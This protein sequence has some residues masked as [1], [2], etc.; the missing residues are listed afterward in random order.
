[1]INKNTNLVEWALAHLKQPA[2]HLKQFDGLSN[3]TIIMPTFKRHDY[4]IRLIVYLSAFKVNLIIVVGQPHCLN[5]SSSP[6]NSLKQ[7]S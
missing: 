7:S 3:L 6:I 1:L 4:V 2:Q 5:V